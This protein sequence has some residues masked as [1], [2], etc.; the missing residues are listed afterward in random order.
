MNRLVI[1]V[2]EH[3]GAINW[4]QVKA[5]AVEGVIIRC[6][7]GE[8]DPGQDDKQWRRNADECVRLGIPFGVYIYS[9]ATNIAGAE[10]EARHVLRCIK[11][12]KLSYPVYLDL[13]EAGTQ[14]GAVERAR[15]FGDIIEGAGYW[16]G[17]YAN[18]SWWN[19]YLG[20][21][22]QYTKWIAQ[23]NSQCDYQGNNKDMW[24]YESTGN[25][26]GISGNVDMNQ[27]Y[28]DFPGEMKGTVTGTAAADPKAC[29]AK[30]VKETG[31]DDQRIY[32]ED[33]G[34][35]FVHL[36]NKKT[37]FYLDVP[38]GKASNDAVLQWYEK[39]DSEAQL[40]KL[41]YEEQGAAKYALLES[42]LAPD[43]Y[44]SVENNG[45]NGGNKIKLWEKMESSKQ[46]FWL[47]QA[48]DG[49][50]VFVHTYSL[51]AIAAV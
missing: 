10:S 37:G 48:S 14:A 18:L 4:D 11:G 9:Y 35:G 23:Y 1:D 41:A 28:R 13:E 45:I 31:E 3:Q 34:D 29:P 38:G 2:S 43:K 27:C 8:D 24:Q 21:L 16:C 26:E 25:V 17:I 30:M 40:W 20:G 5:S 6:G 7:Y 46:K 19:N 32:I 36:K 12:L 39:N 15:R 51:M 49:S 50:Y 33:A 42:K 44:V 22:D 47:K